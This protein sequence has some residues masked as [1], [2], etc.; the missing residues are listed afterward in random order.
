MP[1]DI[2]FAAENLTVTVS[3][4]ASQVMDA[5]T[6]AQGL[7]FRLGDGRSPAEVYVNPAAIAFWRSYEEPQIGPPGNVPPPTGR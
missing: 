7:P 2:Y 4:D 1:T 6:A 5:F 3:E